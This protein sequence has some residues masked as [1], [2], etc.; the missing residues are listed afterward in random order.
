MILPATE[1]QSHCTAPTCWLK[2]AVLLSLLPAAL[3]AKAQ[4]EPPGDPALRRELAQLLEAGEA[5]RAIER[6]QAA[7]LQ[8]PDDPAIRHEYVTFHLAL[9]RNWLSQQ[10]F[11]N[12]L[13][14]IG[15]ILAVEPNHQ[16]A[17][18]MRARIL[19][20]REK[21]GTQSAEITQLLRL[22]LYESA[23]ERVREVRALRPD[24]GPTL[25]AIE[26]A[27]WRG[28]A[29]D[30]YVAGN[31]REAFALY[32]HVL[33]LS[34]EVSP[35][36]R[37]RWSIALALALLESSFGEP[38]DALTRLL[39]RAKDMLPASEHVVVF[40]AITGL[41]AEHAGRY[42]DAGQAYAEALETEWKLPPA[43]R[44]QAMVI[45]LREQLAERLHALYTET[46]TRDREGPWRIVLPDL[47]KQ[48][49]TAHFDVY[50]SNDLVAQRV[51][52]AAELHFAGLSNW[53]ALDSARS[54]AP[55]CEL[56]IHPTLEALQQATGTQGMT[57]A[58]TQTRFQGD[59]VLLRRISLFQDD[60]WLLAATLPHEL[61][62]VL[63]SEAYLG[64]EFPPALET[65]LALQTEP[66]ARQLQFRRLLTPPAPSPAQLLGMT[67][68]P[69][70]QLPF[71]A[72]ADALTSWLLHQAAAT[73]RDRSERSPI[74]I[75]L[76]TFKD[77]Y[78]L[79][80]WK[81]LGW[82]TEA[83]MRAEWGAWYEARRN[84]P[85]MPLMMLAK[86]VPDTPEGQ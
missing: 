16:A 75:V 63:L 24:M 36:L 79:D 70:E 20:A 40:Q 84:P 86:P 52:E 12:C 9:A 2:L 22:E 60:P 17:L 78:A 44:R 23:L 66:P 18:H 58:A 5:E 35:A 56:R 42:L 7:L 71:Y 13:A 21:A 26:R 65:G 28:A 59:R 76:D 74:A 55:R 38:A 67:Q 69:A 80:W 30:H 10:R 33:S 14:A 37:S 83:A 39:A 64:A 27:A 46:R 41:I 73:T 3:P 61:T 32:E 25:A 62:H 57:R 1:R 47:W 81:K 72:H 31:F 6:V 45:G 8:S 53:L 51:A 50:A 34:G 15:A 29:D 48:R 77:G 43:D 19:A 82:Q 11:D 4:E 85:R 68:I 54:W 49:R